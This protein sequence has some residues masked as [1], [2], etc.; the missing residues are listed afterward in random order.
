MANCKYTITIGGKTITDKSYE[1][2]CNFINNNI[3]KIRFGNINDLVFSLDKQSEVDAKLRNLSQS[4]KELES[5]GIDKITGDFLYKDDSEYISVNDL[6]KNPSC[7]LN[8]PFNMET[9]TKLEISKLEEGGMS[10]V[11]A[12]NEL[13]QRLN[14]FEEVAKKAIQIKSIIGTYLA[15]FKNPVSLMTAVEDKSHFNLQS[16][17]YSS[18]ASQMDDVIIKIKEVHGE[19]AKL[20][21]NVR[22]SS[23]LNGLTQKLH[24]TV[25]LIV[26]DSEGVPHIYVFKNSEKVS[27]DWL[28]V[29]DQDIDYKLG[30]YRHMLAANG[31]SVRDTGLYVVPI[32]IDQD[33]GDVYFEEI[34][35]RLIPTKS[36]LNRLTWG[37]GNFF[38]NISNFV[39]ITISNDAIISDIKENVLGNMSKA[40]GTSALQNTRSLISIE[41]FIKSSRVRESDDY[42]KGK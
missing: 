18:I 37:S 35:D 39:P 16:S 36:G 3:Q 8:N 14:H 32:N 6:M 12:V 9:Y 22:L 33:S 28:A 42:S 11:D 38:V 2:L 7:G 20:I 25:D 23:S 10:H 5:I 27:E 26:I 17:V 1:E 4:T 40:F 15:G 24:A 21:P 34:Q 19:N 29:K 13:K 30:F 31:L 41:E